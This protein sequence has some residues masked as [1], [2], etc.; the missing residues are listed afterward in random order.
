M[1]LTCR[2]Q[3]GFVAKT[4][5]II[6]SGASNEKVFLNIVQS[7]KVALP[8]KTKAPKGDCWSIPYT[9]G[10]PHMEKDKKGEN[11]SCFD[12]CFHP[13]ALELSEDHQDFRDLLVTTAMDGVEE[14]CKRQRVEVQLER[15]FHIV[16]GIKYKEGQVLTM[17]IASQHKESWKSSSPSGSSSNI[18]PSTESSTTVSS[19][20]KS[21]IVEAGMDDQPKGDKTSSINPTSKGNTSEATTTAKPS[22]PKKP[23]STGLRRGFLNSPKASLYPEKIPTIR[24]SGSGGSSS[25]APSSPNPQ[26]SIGTVVDNESNKVSTAAVASMLKPNASSA[27]GNQ[28]EAAVSD[29]DLKAVSSKKITRA[30][31]STT[32]QSS[33]VSSS[34]QSEG[35]VKPLV[36]CKH[37]ED[38]TLGDLD[39]IKSQQVH[40]SRPNELIYEIQLPLVSSA[41]NIALDLSESKLVLTYEKIYHLDLKLPYRVVDQKAKAAFDKIKKTL[42]VRLPVI[43]DD[44]VSAITPPVRET[45]GIEEIDQSVPTVDATTNNDNKTARKQPSKDHSRWV[46]GGKQMGDTDKNSGNSLS[47]EVQRQAAAAKER[48]KEIVKGKNASSK[49]R[50][51]ISTSSPEDFG[52]GLDFVPFAE[53]SGF[54]SGFVYKRGDQGLGYYRDHGKAA[55]APVTSPT[56]HSGETEDGALVTMPF[57]PEGIEL[58]DITYEARESPKTLALLLQIPCVVADSLLIDITGPHTIEVRCIAL[59]GQGQGPQNGSHCAVMNSNGVAKIYYGQGFDLDPDCCPGGIDAKSLR[60][61][62]AGKNAAIVIYKVLPNEVWKTTEPTWLRKREY[63]GSLTM[64]ASAAA[65]ADNSVGSVSESSASSRYISTSKESTKQ[66]NT[67]GSSTGE[68]AEPAS[69]S[70]AIEAAAMAMSSMRFHTDLFSELD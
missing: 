6:K 63:R 68:E 61:D 17:M 67:E 4:H 34:P 49:P 41:N 29:A 50:S 1:C 69:S 36:V 38:V 23:V 20:K 12:V 14:M 62:V 13:E 47:E 56:D 5:K 18:S 43:K 48:A 26:Q 65:V 46:E 44:A 28:K 16:K 66:T 25:A 8:T 22:T 33:V 15:K 54:R 45:S 58:H 30:S 3:P 7:E 11:A 31:E 52:S 2:P 32:Q 70:H 55:L 42:T 53:F 60:F 37:R 21:S 51:T 40:S 39:G 64:K 57:P 35:P 27:S 10:P 9:V 19:G 24:P 59:A